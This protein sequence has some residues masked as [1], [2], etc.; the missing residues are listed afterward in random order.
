MGIRSDQRVA[1]CYGE[2]VQQV[3]IG[4]YTEMSSD[5]IMFNKRHI[6]LAWDALHA[7]RQY[8]DLPLSTIDSR[9]RLFGL[10][11][12]NQQ[13]SPYE[14][15]CLMAIFGPAKLVMPQ[16]GWQR[17]PVAVAWLTQ[18]APLIAQ[19]AQGAKLLKKGYWCHPTRNRRIAQAARA[20]TTHNSSTLAQL[21]PAAVEYFHQYAPQRVAVVTDTLEHAITIAGKLLGWQLLMGPDA[22]TAGFTADQLNLLRDRTSRWH[23]QEHVILTTAALDQIDVAHLDVMIWAGGGSSCPLAQT[24]LLCPVD[25]P[26]RLLLIDVDDRHHPQLRRWSRARR[27]TYEERDW[28][29]PG[30]TALTGRIQ[31]YLQQQR[32]CT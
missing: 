5:D 23:D 3:V 17:Q 27:K 4:T 7:I 12:E 32:A 6:V 9:F 15:D 25:R 29:P 18:H 13:L 8:A 10:L 16:I 2:E 24:R 28:Y 11:P 26:R 22:N 20:I 21:V 31:R 30:V 14:Q 1:N 19:S